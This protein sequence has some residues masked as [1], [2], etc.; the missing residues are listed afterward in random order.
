LQLWI[1]SQ[2][3]KNLYQYK[4]EG[5]DENWIQSGTAHTATYTNLD[6]DIYTF[7]VKGSNSDGVW[8]ETEH[9][10]NWLFFHHGT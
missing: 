7:H 4:L 1:F 5:F 10:W 3:G 2:P 6:P 9:Q 8:N